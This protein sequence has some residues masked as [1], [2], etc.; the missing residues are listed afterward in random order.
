MV[1]GSLYAIG[2]FLSTQIPLIGPFLG[3]AVDVLG[4][5]VQ[6]AGRGVFG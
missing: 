6:L 4:A 1:S 2:S 3:G 5:I